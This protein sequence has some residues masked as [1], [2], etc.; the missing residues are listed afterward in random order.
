MEIGILNKS[1]IE[2][3][4]IPFHGHV[5]TM[6][7]TI[8]EFELARNPL[9]KPEQDNKQPNYLIFAENRNGDKIKIGAG[10]HRDYERDGKTGEMISLTFD[11]PSFPAPLH[12]TAFKGD[13]E[14]Q[15]PITW[16][17]REK[18]SS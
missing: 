8:K 18:T 5:K 1:R 14:Y 16:R 15:W 4:S 2:E 10:W 13:N 3:A 17:R 9:K 11:D 7:L 6:E 12:V